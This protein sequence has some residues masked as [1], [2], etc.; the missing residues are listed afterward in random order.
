MTPASEGLVAGRFELGPRVGQGGMGTVFRGVDTHTGETVALKL[1][2]PESVLHD[3]GNLER[4]GREGEALRRLNHPNIVKV[5]ATVKEGERHYLVMEWMGGGSLEDV[6]RSNRE[7]VPIERVLRIALDLCDALT[8]S[9]RL[10]IIHRDLKPANVLIAD[11]GT[12]RLTDFGV[13]HV[14]GLQ[15]VTLPNAIVGTLDYL[16]PEVLRGEEVDVRT[17]VWAFGVLLFE[18]LT[19][20]RPFSDANFARTIYAIANKP[21][22]DLEAL[23]PD[24]PAALVDLVFRMLEKN[25]EQRI[26]SVR[27]VGAELENVLFGRSGPVPRNSPNA[28]IPDSQAVSEGGLAHA[29]TRPVRAWHGTEGE[30]PAWRDLPAEISPFIGREEELAKLAWLLADPAVRLITILAP[31]GMGKSRFALEASRRM[32]AGIGNFQQTSR[33]VERF[34]DGAFF[35]PLAPLE[36]PEHVVSTIADAIGLELQ[37]DR[38]PAEQLLVYVRNKSILLV[39]DNFEHVLRSAGAVSDILRAA[40]QSVALVTS[41]ER[42]G[43]SGETIFELGSMDLPESD[44]PQMQRQSSAIELFAATARRVA[45]DF[46]LSPETTASVRRICRLVGGMPLGI[47]LA[48]SWVGALRPDEIAIEIGRSFDFLTT[49]MRDVPERQ[50]S[51]RAAF[52]HSFN[53][54]GEPERAVFSRLCV[55]RGGFT[56]RAAE[57]VADAGIRSLASL[58]NKSLLRR[59][60]NTGRYEIHEVLRQ[61]AEERLSQS[62]DNHER[63]LD[64]HAAYYA[65][66]LAEGTERLN[67]REPVAVNDEIPVA[68]L[69]GIEVEFDNV[70]AAWKYMLARKQLKRIRGALYPLMAYYRNRTTFAEAERVFRAAAESLEAPRESMSIEQA[71]VL[72]VTLRVQAMQCQSPRRAL[73]LGSRALQLLDE[74]AQATERGDVLITM[75]LSHAQLGERKQ[76]TDRL[77][78]A[79]ALFRAANKRSGVE[80]ALLFLGQLHAWAGDYRKAEAPL[81]ESIASQERDATRSLPL[82][83]ALT[84]LG[85]VMTGQ[86]DYVEGCRLLSLALRMNDEF[87]DIL[88]QLDGQFSLAQARRSLGDYAEAQALALSCLK[89]SQEVGAPDNEAWCWILLGDI[90]KDQGLYAD[91]AQNLLKAQGIGNERDHPKQAAAARL[92]FGEIALLNGDDALAEANF[93]RDLGW[94]EES[95]TIWGIVYALTGL[96][97]V[98]CH[99][100][101]H[102]LARERFGRALATALAC[103]A[104]PMANHTAAGVALLLAKTGQVVRAVECLGRLK[105]DPAT[106]RC[107]HTQWLDPLL[108]QLKERLPPDD[109]AAALERGKT[110]D[111]QMIRDELG[112][113]AG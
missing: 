45:P 23:R 22:A 28:T 61:Y 83:H 72:A 54:L 59:D 104:Q 90:L 112:Q 65:A 12:P 87:N 42:L 11:D 68:V 111:L 50:R 44:V 16:S 58:T 10:D 105:S 20:V 41:R 6:L 77:E 89:L 2:N 25:R 47:V 35:V 60:P 53:L 78:E 18:M 95:E 113:N 1:L 31:G 100:G 13:A 14:V 88:G 4:F 15:S 63:T 98:A 102:D 21:A 3:P 96:G 76:G 107:T 52:E 34:A 7:P 70:R 57:V 74:P 82:V 62:P 40:P 93:S 43:L 38:E 30:P 85:I 56:R 64:L 37:R 27:Q 79:V 51:L 5:L 81:R 49:E 86:G 108:A 19:G 32:L 97:Y 80:W 29:P 46:E 39:L 84:G 103:K 94:F 109:L 110:L 67:D 17:D 26:P 69:D 8:R 75:A 9:H 73:D 55:F 99:Q 36:S 106:E 33:A 101:H 24:C 48:A 66:F 92:S 71:T 91:A